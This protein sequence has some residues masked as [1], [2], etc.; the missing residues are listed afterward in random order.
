M[1]LMRVVTINSAG[2]PVNSFVRDKETGELIDD[3]M[4][5]EFS[6][7]HVKMNEPWMAILHRYT[8]EMVGDDWETCEEQVYIEIGVD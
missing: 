7:L 5:I 1:G 3:I 8:G 6:D 2:F 4:H